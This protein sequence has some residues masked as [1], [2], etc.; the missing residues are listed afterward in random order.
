MQYVFNADYFSNVSSTQD[1]SAP[2]LS[3]TDVEQAYKTV[4]SKVMRQVVLEQVGMVAWVAARSSCT[5]IPL[6]GSRL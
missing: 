6:F 3:H 5:Q 4:R 2:A 1:G